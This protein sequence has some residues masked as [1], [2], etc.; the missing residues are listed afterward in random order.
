MQL[1]PALNHRNA[2]QQ[3]K[4]E[5]LAPTVL[6]QTCNDWALLCPTGWYWSKVIQAVLEVESLPPACRPPTNRTQYC[7]CCCCV[8]GESSAVMLHAEMISIRAR[9]RTSSIDKTSRHFN[10][11]LLRRMSTLNDSLALR[12]QSHPLFNGQRYRSC[13]RVIRRP[14]V[15]RY[16]DLHY[17]QPTLRDRALPSISMATEKRAYDQRWN[18][19]WE[20]GLSKGEVSDQPVSEK[21]YHCLFACILTLQTHQTTYKSSGM[22]RFDASS[23]SPALLA[24]IKEGKLQPRG[25]RIFIPG[26]G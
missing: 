9:G 11:S 19:I 6:V 15:Y 3:S 10:T 26:C 14:P 2:L 5:S 13:P 8:I 22:Q 1:L 17:S 18:N 16:H 24:L 7:W 23:S 25:K 21:R 20:A 4:P 12:R